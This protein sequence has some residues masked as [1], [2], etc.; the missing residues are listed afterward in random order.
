MPDF[1][2]MRVE[3]HWVSSETMEK[4]REYLYGKRWS[5]SKVEIQDD[6]MWYV[7]KIYWK[8]EDENNCFILIWKDTNH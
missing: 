2:K 8:I 1:I 4:V 7:V 3:V 6:T 5:L